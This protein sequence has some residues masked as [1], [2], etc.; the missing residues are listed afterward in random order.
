MQ[1]NV[2]KMHDLKKY[3]ISIPLNV[4]LE[5]IP[6]QSFP[7]Q[8]IPTWTIPSFSLIAANAPSNQQKLDNF[9][10]DI[11]SCIN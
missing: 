4:K 3:D 10:D 1:C 5:Q 6:D 9:P 2:Q 8:E 11:K 7:W